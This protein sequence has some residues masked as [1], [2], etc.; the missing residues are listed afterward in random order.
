MYD[1]FTTMH[2]YFNRNSLISTKQGHTDF[3]LYKCVYLNFYKNLLIIITMILFHQKDSEIDKF[4]YFNNSI[5][6]KHRE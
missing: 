5:M 1:I 3:Y 2:Y 4:K 6:Q